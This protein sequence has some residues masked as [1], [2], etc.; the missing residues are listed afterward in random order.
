MAGFYYGIA[1]QKKM[2]HDEKLLPETKGASKDVPVIR[3]TTFLER[4]LGLD[5]PQTPNGAAWKALVGGTIVSV[6][7]C[8][9]L[10]GGLS[11][12]LGVRSVRWWMELKCVDCAH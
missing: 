1:K 7:G 3:R 8:V 4:R 10:L 5:R 11:A 12:V 6:S 9:V 2:V